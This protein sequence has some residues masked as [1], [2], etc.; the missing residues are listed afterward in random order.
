MFS[1][2]PTAA[3]ACFIRISF[4]TGD[5]GD[6]CVRKS[7]LGTRAHAAA[8]Q[9]I[10]TDGSEIAGKRF[11]AEAFVSDH[12]FIDDEFV[13]I[14][15]GWDNGTFSGVLGST[16]H[17]FNEITSTWFQSP[18]E[19]RLRSYG[20]GW[21][22]L[23][24][25]LIDATYGYLHTEDD[26]NLIFAKEGGTSTIHVDPMLYSKDEETGEPSYLLN[27]ESVSVD[28]EEVDEIPEWITIEVA[29]EDYTKAKGVDD[30]GNEYEY[31]VNGIDYDLVITLAALPEGVENRTAKIVFW[32]TGAKLTVNLTQDIDP[33]GIS[34]VVE[35]TPIKNSRAFNLAGQPV[36]NSYKG[37]V[38]KDGKKILV[39]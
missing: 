34:T 19:T 21:P 5:Y 16:E 4:S 9:K 14:I 29:N 24:I 31:F 27:V 10:H 11:M 7:L 23:F 8:D 13:I 3:A 12:L 33:D 30:E 17:N 25:G 18:G 1:H 26:T 2:C 28:G 15:E 38:V 36:G 6:S 22:Q 20:G 39:K 32:Q 35:Q 37:V